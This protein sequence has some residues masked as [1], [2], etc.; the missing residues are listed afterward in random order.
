M[1]SENILGSQNYPEQK[2]E[3]NKQN[4]GGFATPDLKMYSR[5]IKRLKEQYGISMKET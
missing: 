2:K 3:T 4:L 5:A 1:E